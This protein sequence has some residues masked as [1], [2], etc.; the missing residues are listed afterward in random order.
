MKRNYLR[1]LLWD[2]AC[3]SFVAAMLGLPFA[4]YFYNMHP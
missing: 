3:A 2:L 1:G 4:V